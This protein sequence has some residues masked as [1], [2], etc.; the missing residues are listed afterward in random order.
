MIRFTFFSIC[1][2]WIDPESC[3]RAITYVHLVMTLFRFART[4]IWIKSASYKLHSTSWL[5]INICANE[6]T[7]MI[8]LTLFYLKRYLKLYFETWNINFILLIFRIKEFYWTSK[9]VVF[10]LIISKTFTSIWCQQWTRIDY[11]KSKSLWF[12]VFW[13]GD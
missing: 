7:K 10:Y 8:V 5:Y 4:Y 13:V 3:K 9:L 1:F 2:W 12:V 6:Q 11:F